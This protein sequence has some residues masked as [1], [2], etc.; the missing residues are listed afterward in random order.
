MKTIIVKVDDKYYTQV[1]KAINDLTVT[2][3]GIIQLEESDSIN[4][5]FNKR[6]ILV[7]LFLIFR[8]NRVKIC[9][10]LKDLFKIVIKV[11]KEIIDMRIPYHYYLCI[12]FNR[13]RLKGR[14]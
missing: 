9:F 14:G 1:M 12:A 13:F 7:Y 8:H 11:I 4:M 6:R 10:D 3:D 5:T 2:A